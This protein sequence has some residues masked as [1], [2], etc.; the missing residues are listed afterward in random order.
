MERG[1]SA[2]EMSEMKLIGDFLVFVLGSAKDEL[3]EEEVKASETE[4]DSNDSLRLQ[5][6]QSESTRVS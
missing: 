2:G 6:E 5:S 1:S 4:S 3:N